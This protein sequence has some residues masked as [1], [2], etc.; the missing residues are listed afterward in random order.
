MKDETVFKRETTT[1]PVS[2]EP[3]VTMLSEAGKKLASYTA[4]S[5]AFVVRTSS[6]PA[7]KEK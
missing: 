2:P 1:E 5:N 7:V 6:T 4:P 3:A